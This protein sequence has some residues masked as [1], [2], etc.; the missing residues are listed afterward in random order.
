MSTNDTNITIR[1]ATAADQ[2][3]LTQL[4]ALDGTRAIT[5][6]DVLVAEAGGRVRAA[7]RVQDGRH[8]ADPFWPSAELVQLLRVH[9]GTLPG[10]ARRRRFARAGLRHRG[11]AMAGSR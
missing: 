4:A 10:P 8:A 1:G 11:V 3:D 5:G 6:D 2:N 9:A 7:F